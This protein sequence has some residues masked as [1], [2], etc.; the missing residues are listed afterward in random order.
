M[1]RRPDG[2]RSTAT[3]S[4]LTWEGHPRLRR[5]ASPLRRLGI[6]IQHEREGK[7]RGRSITIA[8]KRGEAG[9]GWETPSAPSGPPQRTR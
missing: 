2:H 7:D 8:Q 1:T 6:E 9:Q 3:R 4:R 5:V